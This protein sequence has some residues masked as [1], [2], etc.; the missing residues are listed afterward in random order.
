VAQSATKNLYRADQDSLVATTT[1]LKT[2]HL[3]I[4]LLYRANVVARRGFALP[5]EAISS[6]R[7]FSVENE[8]A[9]PP[10]TK[11]LDKLDNQSAARNDI[12]WRDVR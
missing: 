8:I 4:K 2:S 11:C 10:K 7:D 12:I 5:D 3:I 1:L 9:S 6:W